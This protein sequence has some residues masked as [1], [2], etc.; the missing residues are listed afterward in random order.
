MKKVV[1]VC[2]MISA[3]FFL[4]KDALAATEAS[5]NAPLSSKKASAV[6]TIAQSGLPYSINPA[7]TNY[8]ATIAPQ[9]VK[10]S[11]FLL[12]NDFVTKRQREAAR[13]AN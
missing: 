2:L 7:R 5:P 1:L 4:L 11:K 10:R 13:G 3:I 8:M 12:P 9:D 6:K